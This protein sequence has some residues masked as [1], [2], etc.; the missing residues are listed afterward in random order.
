VYFDYKRDWYNH[1]DREKPKPPGSPS[2]GQARPECQSLGKFIR[3]LRTV[4]TTLVRTGWAKGETTCS[5]AARH[6]PSISTEQPNRQDQG[7]VTQGNVASEKEGPSLSQ[8]NPVGQWLADPSFLPCEL[9][10]PGVVPWTHFAAVLMLELLGG[11]PLQSWSLVSRSLSGFDLLTVEKTGDRCLL[12][13]SRYHHPAECYNVALTSPVL[14]GWRCAF[15]TTPTHPLIL[16]RYMRIQETNVQFYSKLR[17]FFISS[18]HS[19]FAAPRQYQ[20]MTGVLLTTLVR[21]QL[22]GFTSPKSRMSIT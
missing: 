7:G 13:L 10:G 19:G 9:L 8:P 21:K 17:L 6:W 1:L 15:C 16:D 11:E 3:P 18:F 4:H 2:V 14:D 22:K 20:S 5:T 12:S